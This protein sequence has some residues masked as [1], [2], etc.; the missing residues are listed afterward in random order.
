M[1]N[2]FLLSGVRHYIG[3]FWEILDEP[4]SQFAIE[5]YKQLFSGGSIGNAVLKARNALVDRYGEE[6]IIWASYVMYGDPTF[7]YIDQLQL[8]A[9][10]STKRSSVN[11]PAIKDRTREEIVDFTEKRKEHGVILRRWLVGATALLLVILGARGLNWH[12]SSHWQALEQK[13][14]GHYLAGEHK[15]AEGVCQQLRVDA[16][17][18]ALSALILGNIN[19]SRGDMDEAKRLFQLVLEN[20]SETDTAKAEAL[21]G[22]GRLASIEA[23]PDAAMDFYRRAADAAPTNASALVSRAVLMERLGRYEEALGLYRL[24]SALNPGDAGIK[25]AAGQIQERLAQMKDEAKQ[26]RID[27]LI[28]DILAADATPP[29][30]AEQVWTSA[31]LTVWLLD[32]Q[33]SGFHPQEGT[34]RMIHGLIADSL[35][36][37]PRV[38]LV[39][40]AMLDQL[41]AE[42]K[43]EA[44]QLTDRETAI[45]VG[46]LVAARLLMIGRLIFSHGRV[47]AMVRMVECETG[48]VGASIFDD[49][50]PATSPQAAAEVLSA[51]ILDGVRQ[52]HPIRGVVTAVNENNAL[53]DVGRRHG[54]TAGMQFMGPVGDVV[55][56]IRSVR[57][58][59]SEAEVISAKT[60]IQPGLK[61]EERIGDP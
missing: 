34:E 33:T 51:K 43:L 35:I 2:A 36:K 1:A 24:A 14:M 9:E 49:F 8:P 18:R 19:L 53:L 39:E 7:N 32:F 22:L 59:E 6:T 13:A 16:P 52:M 23:N 54:V 21:I 41:L 60:A 12:R 29:L 10:E 37:S 56:L 57:G 58:M 45:A 3:T 15:Q 40:R 44:A 47:Q 27:K 38:Q 5:F 42:L 26:A 25:V 4:G 46:R 61:V 28:E 50:G 31:P 17:Q 11:R 30:P 20:R 48:L 55:V